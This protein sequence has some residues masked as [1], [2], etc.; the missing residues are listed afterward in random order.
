MTVTGVKIR[1]LLM[2]S[3]FYKAVATVYLEGYAVN[4]ILVAEEAG[5]VVIRF[6]FI[7]NRKEDGSRVFAFAPVSAQARGS[8]EKEVAQ[9]YWKY[10][11]EVDGKGEMGYNEGSER[12]RIGKGRRK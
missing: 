3:G 8:I 1:P 7:P 11:G 10:K 6:P 5:K 9:A 4:G 2:N 12:N